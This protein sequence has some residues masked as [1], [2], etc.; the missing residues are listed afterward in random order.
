MDQPDNKTVLL[1]ACKSKY[2][3]NKVKPYAITPNCHVNPQ[4]TQII[5]RFRFLL[6]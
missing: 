2:C 4:I 3:N 6:V 1:E 5:V